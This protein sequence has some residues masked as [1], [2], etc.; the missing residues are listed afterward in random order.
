M[1]LS[2]DE[3]RARLREMVAAGETF[4]D[5]GLASIL[6]GAEDEGDVD[7]DEALGQLDRLAEPLEATV[8]TG[9]LLQGV[10]ALAEHLFEGEGFRGNQE[11][12]EDPRNS[13]LHQVLS[14]RQG[15][16]I[17]L[18]ILFIEVG[19]RLGIGL[20]GVS[21]PAHFLVGI[22]DYPELFVDPFGGGRILTMDEC[23]A[24][25]HVRTGGTL[26][27]DRRYLTPTPTTEI[28]TR[29]SR[30]LKTIFVRSADYDAAL[31]AVDRILVLTPRDWMEV[32]DRGAIQ[33]R[34]GA[35]QLAI[36]DLTTY[37][38]QVK[39]PTDRDWVQGLIEEARQGLA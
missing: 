20:H 17:T 9:S 1:I 11:D 22:E 21:F 31:R 8:G 38:E 15:I 27:F 37:L 33:L 16:P 7:V 3:A 4:L 23:D 18:S 5:L 12:Y 24:L 13:Y 14:R 6:V 35:F 25:L 10:A 29:V 30:N 36:D 32:R 34:R 28:L 39:D 2:A 19:R 26:A